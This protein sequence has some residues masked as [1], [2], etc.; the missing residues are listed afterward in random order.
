ML[1]R[2]AVYGGGARASPARQSLYMEARPLM[3]TTYKFQVSIPVGSLLPRDRYV[4]TFHMQHSIGALADADLASMC[5]DIAALWRTR[6][7]HLANEVDVKAYD[8]DAVPN[9]PRAHHV[10]NPGAI[11]TVGAPRE[12][13]LVLSYA[14][15]NRAV[16]DQRGRMYL[17]PYLAA[18][19]PSVLGDRP[20]GAMLD[21]VLEWYTK[22]NE[23]LPDLGGVDWKFGV[24]STTYKHFTQTQQAWCNDDWDVQR[25]RGWRESTRVSA[26][27]EG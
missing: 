21:W 6:Y 11:W 9:Y 19:L 20:S 23:S 2:T 10:D 8:T 18:S 1:R 7:G 15:T 4:N 14:A 3:P 24:W 22:P 13:A 26:T 17:A 25:R 27:R 16:K 5:T 12:I